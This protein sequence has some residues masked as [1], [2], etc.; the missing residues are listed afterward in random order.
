[1][2][3]KVLKD[4]KNYIPGLDTIRGIAIVAVIFYHLI[5]HI[6]T[7]GF[8][9]VNLFLV[10]SGF[11][12]NKSLDREYKEKKKIDYYQ[13]LVR[14]LK[15]TFIPMFWML[16]TLGAF[17]FIFSKGLLNNY[18][19]ESLSSMV[20][21]NNWWQIKLGS[22]YFS[23]F[24]NPSTITHLWYL[25]V[26]V[27]FYIIWII[28]F[29]LTK[30]Y[31]E[32]SKSE[33]APTIYLTITIISAILMAIIFKSGGDPTR[34]YYGTDTRIFSFSF[35]ALLSIYH[36]DN[37]R[38]RKEKKV[39][40]F[41]LVSLFIIILMFLVVQDNS[42]F[43]FRGG[44]LI[45]TIFSATLIFAATNPN[46]T[47]SKIFESSIILK[48]LGKRSYS[49]YLW[50]YPVMTVF[51]IL[52][53]GKNIN[54]IFGYLI[55]IL[56]ILL[57]AQ[58]SY[59]LFE[60][61]SLYIPIYQFR[62]LKDTKEIQTASKV[63]FS[64][65]TI[66]LVIFILGILSFKPDNK[67]AKNLE[68]KIEENNLKIKKDKSNK[69]IDLDKDNKKDKK[70]NKEIE[71]KEDEE[72]SNIEGLT[73]KEEEFSKN[74]EITFIGDSML[75]MAT[76]PIKQVFPKAEIDGKVG[77]QLYQSNSVVSALKSENRLY[78]TVVIIL[79]AN[80]SFTDSQFNS[81][82]KAIGEDKKIFLVTTNADTEWKESVNDSFKSKSKENKNMFLVDWNKHLGNNVEWLEPDGTHPNIEGAKEMVKIIAKEI[83]KQESKNKKTIQ[84]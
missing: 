22:S 70:N 23:K 50:Y 19:G 60:K 40:I 71:K 56:V 2:N 30:K 15:R 64:I 1:M 77:R 45:F 80:G 66:A 6:F 35:G 62:K 79:G 75:I 82:A 42:T 53:K 29:I 21:I 57:L 51:S 12:I 17:L 9:G 24:L 49:I 14:R 37:I 13:F 73:K 59:Y 63:L 83:Y 16:I 78:D 28:V 4:R 32:K 39:R 54:M 48:E 26:Q 46:M 43:T 20:F 69:K 34:V 11:L 27:Q 68:K 33:K 47:V 36:R 52:K 72:V 55:Q 65:F 25:S 38:I 44:M 31:S 3:T 81:F 7:G 5:P 8:L 61:N 84:D 67:A 76:E 41:G 58:I 18:L 10:L 74:K